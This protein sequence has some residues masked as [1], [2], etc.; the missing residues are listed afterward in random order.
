MYFQ[1][2]GKR[3]A[4]YNINIFL[5]KKY[6]DRKKYLFMINECVVRNVSYQ[7]FPSGTYN[8]FYGHERVDKKKT[9]WR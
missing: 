2:N 3:P 8:I 4:F 5:L 9:F 6:Y 7:Y 1:S